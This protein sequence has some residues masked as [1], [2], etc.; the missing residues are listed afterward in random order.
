[1]NKALIIGIVAIVFIGAGSYLVLH[2]SNN[3]PT[4]SNTQNATPASNPP[5]NTNQQVAA[6][7]TYETNGFS[8]SHTTVKSGDRLAI[9]NSSSSDL[10]LES[11][12][13]PAHT[14]DS[15]LNVGLVGTG[16]TKTFIVTKT[17]TFGYHN[18][19]NS[20]DTGTITIQ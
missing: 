1:M 15:D 7:I 10:Q 11:D 17:G 14:D 13:H 18:H 20:S 4:A 16:Q 8:P 5:S 12:P 2:K 9:K 6:T 3:T 19:L